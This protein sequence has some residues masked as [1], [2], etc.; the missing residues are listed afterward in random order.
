MSIPQI[1]IGY[2]CQEGKT[3]SL[4]FTLLLALLTTSVFNNHLIMTQLS[5]DNDPVNQ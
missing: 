4:Y 2:K 1:K 5:N 3:S